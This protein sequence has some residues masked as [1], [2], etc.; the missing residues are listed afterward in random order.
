MGINNFDAI[1]KATRIFK[2]EKTMKFHHAASIE[3]KVSIWI[4][5]SKEI[6][7]EVI[8]ALTPNETSI[9]LFLG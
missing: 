5:Y 3:F 4:L 6:A 8:T 9:D 2:K 1:S 7:L